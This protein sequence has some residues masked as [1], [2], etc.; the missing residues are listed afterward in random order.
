VRRE[1]NEREGAGRR[2]FPSEETARREEQSWANWSHEDLV[3][4][5]RGLLWQKRQ[6][7]GEFVPNFPPATI[8]RQELVHKE[9]P[10][11]VYDPQRKE[12]FRKL[13]D[14]WDVI[15][16]EHYPQWWKKPGENVYAQMDAR[17]QLSLTYLRAKDHQESRPEI[18]RLDPL[19]VKILDALAEAADIPH[20]RGQAEI[21]IPEHA[22]H[23]VEEELQA[24][25]RRDPKK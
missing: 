19:Q 14:A 22:R 13:R 21:T 10:Q 23:V 4:A 6:S 7:Y 3:G 11:I 1:V 18:I 5:F 15:A 12:F 8:I 25:H 20:Q 2:N 24:L 9:G 16:Y 17:W